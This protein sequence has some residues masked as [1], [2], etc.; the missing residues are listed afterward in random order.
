[1]SL[2]K[3]IV[4]VIAGVGLCAINV[5]FF[6]WVSGGHNALIV[7]LLAGLGLD[8]LV[9]LAFGAGAASVSVTGVD[10]P[11]CPGRQ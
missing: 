10:S 4:V 2:G 7:T 3:P 11:S 8:T 6:Y 5:P 1:M 9:F